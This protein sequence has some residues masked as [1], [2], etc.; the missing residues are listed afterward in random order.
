MLGERFLPKFHYT[1]SIWPQPQQVKVTE[2]F[3]P[4]SPDVDIVYQDES[5][6]CEVVD[7]AIDRYGTLIR[8]KEW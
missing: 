3:N 8:K 2:D 6:R 5:A 7:D 1:G 4:L